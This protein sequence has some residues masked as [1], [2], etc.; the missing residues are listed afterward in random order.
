MPEFIRTIV[1]K[2]NSVPLAPAIL[3][4][5]G[6]LLTMGLTIGGLL[7]PGNAAMVGYFIGSL[8]IGLVFIFPIS[9]IGF[10]LRAARSHR[11]PG[12][13]WLIPLATIWVATLAMLLANGIVFFVPGVL[14]D[15]VLALLVLSNATFVP[16]AFSV[17]LARVVAG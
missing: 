15:A 14:L 9:A 4:L 7:A 6:S 12:V 10:S 17:A 16:L 1:E 11:S 5:A 13:V 2:V 8:L 3:A